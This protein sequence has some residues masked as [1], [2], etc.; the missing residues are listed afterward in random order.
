MKKSAWRR[1]PTTRKPQSGRRPEVGWRGLDWDFQ[2]VDV[3]QTARLRF[4]RSTSTRLIFSTGWRRLLENS[5]QTEVFYWSTS[6]RLRFS[7]GRRWTL[8]FSNCR[9]PGRRSTSDV[10]DAVDV[11]F[12]W[13]FH[14]AHSILSSHVFFSTQ[15][16]P[17]EFRFKILIARYQP[18]NMKTFT[19][20][21]LKDTEPT[22]FS[23][24][25]ITCNQGI[26]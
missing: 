5:D 14:H 22:S 2:V 8:I 20:C 3:D 17:F 12:Y 23:Y 25:S 16:L 10:V 18:V 4:S 7:T 15:V 19:S 9:R 21:Y 24:L 6:T 26:Q 13:L 1:P 11:L